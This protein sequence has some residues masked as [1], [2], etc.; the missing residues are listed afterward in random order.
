MRK[1]SDGLKRLF[2]WRLRTLLLLVMVIACCLAYYVRWSRPY[3]LQAIA[4]AKL[5]SIGA[6]VKAEAAEPAWA[7]VLVGKKRFFGICP[8]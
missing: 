6:S 5:E 7:A 4:R 3:R 8:G 2:R 1:S